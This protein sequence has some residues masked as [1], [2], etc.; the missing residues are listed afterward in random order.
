M[1]YVLNTFGI[2]TT[3]EITTTMIKIK[4]DWL[5]IGE[6]LPEAL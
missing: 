3:A 6:T 2:Q 1:F 5:Q 4:L